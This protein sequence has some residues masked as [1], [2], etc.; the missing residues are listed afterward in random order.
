MVDGLWPCACIGAFNIRW[1][2]DAFASSAFVGCHFVSIFLQIFLNSISNSQNVCN[3]IS[4]CGI[5]QTIELKPKKQSKLRIFGIY[6]RKTSEN[7]QDYHRMCF[8]CK[9]IFQMH[10]TIDV[11]LSSIDATEHSNYLPDWR[12]IQCGKMGN[13]RNLWELFGEIEINMVERWYTMWFYIINTNLDW[14]G[15]ASIQFSLKFHQF[16]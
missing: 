1:S 16:H 6:F 11:W 3:V 2:M 15:T 14:F 13:V 9:S 4:S 5:R 10:W 7:G 12:T 8:E